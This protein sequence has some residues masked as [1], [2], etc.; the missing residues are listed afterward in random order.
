[1][2]SIVISRE[3]RPTDAPSGAVLYAATGTALRPRDPPSRGGN[4]AH[5]QRTRERRRL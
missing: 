1:L 3:H 4:S 2:V 5:P